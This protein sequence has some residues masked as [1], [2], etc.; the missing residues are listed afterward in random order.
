MEKE[1]LYKLI[2]NSGLIDE[3]DIRFLNSLINRYPYFYPARVLEL[4]GLKETKSAEFN[5]KLKQ[6]A[7]L[8]PSR[9]N[10]F[11]TLN[12]APSKI[13]SHKELDASPTETMLSP[14][15]EAETATAG[16]IFQ[17]DET[18]SVDTLSEI[19]DDLAPIQEDPL[20][21]EG[22]LLELG[23]SSEPRQHKTDEEAYLDPQL[24]TLEIPKGFINDDA[25]ADAGFGQFNREGSQKQSSEKLTKADDNQGTK[26]IEEKKKTVDQATLIEAFIETNPRIVP[27]QRPEELP[28][29]QEDISLNSIKEP[30]DAIS[31][32][33]AA[34]HIAQGQNSRAISI[35]EKLCLRFPEKRAYFVAQ[36]EKLKNRPDK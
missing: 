25:L 33:L 34:I 17:L 27:K 4:L 36:I 22:E 2:E 24:Y 13:G 26:E 16:A 11:L 20:K 29:I 10:L 21:P 8:S 31:E 28:E 32:S 30:E 1:Q 6:T 9:Y 14:E 15:P 23:D 35:Y 19:K 3:Q 12:P 5:Q 7:A 18:Q